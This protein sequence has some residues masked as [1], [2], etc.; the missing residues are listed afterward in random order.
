MMRMFRY[1]LPLLAVLAG[2][3]K[4][5]QEIPVIPE[6]ESEEATIVFVSERPQT[7]D[8]TRTHWDGTTILWDQAD[9]IRMGYTVDGKWQNATGNAS[10]T[11][12]KLYGSQ[13]TELT[14]DGAVASFT[15]NISFTGTTQGE[16]VFYAVFPGGTVESTMTAAPVTVVTLPATQTPLADSF[17]RLADLMLGHS[18]DEYT[19]RP[20][21]P[22][23][24]VWDRVVAHGQITLKALPGAVSGEKVTS[25][26]LTAQE[27]A[28][29]VGPQNMNIVTGEYSATSN[30]EEPNKIVIKGDNLI[31]D[32]N[33]NVTF[34]MS[35]LPV[36][37]TSLTIEVATNKA[38]YIRSIPS[39]ERTFIANRRNILPINMSK[40]S[41]TDI[42]GPSYRL[43]T[44]NDDLGEGNYLI[45]YTVNGT[46]AYVLSGKASGNFGAYASN[47]TVTDGAIEY[48]EGNPYNIV[49]KRT[50]DGYS[51]KQGDYYLGYTLTST[52]K[53]NY[54]YFNT[55]YSSP[56]YDWT[57]SVGS[58]GDATITNVY[59]TVR[60][61][62]WN[63]TSGQER[64]ACY[65]GTQK[66]VQLYKL[67]SEIPSLVTKPAT[68]KGV[69]SAKLN[70]TFANLGRNVTEPR[71]LWGTS[72]DN[73]SNTLYVQDFDVDSG[74]FHATLSGLQENTT[75]YYQAVV[76]YCVDGQNYLTL[77][78]DVLSFRTLPE[79]QTT[80]TKPGYL[81]CGEIPAVYLSGTKADGPEAFPAESDSDYELNW[82]SWYRYGVTGNSDQKVVSH[83]FKVDGQQYRNYSML[84]DRTKKAALWVAFAMNTGTYPWLVGR[85]DKWVS[86]PALDDSWQPNLSSGYQE[87]STYSRGHQVASNDRRTTT[88][89]TRQT[90]YFSNMTPQLSG[91]NGGQWASLEEDIQKIGNATSGNDT[92]YVVT[93]PVFGSNYGTTKDKSGTDCAVPT[94]YFKCIMKVTYSN[95]KPTAAM[96][97]AYLMNHVNSGS[98][99]QEVT[100]RSLEELTGFDFFANI[101]VELQ[102]TA[103]NETHPTSDFPQ[104][105]ISSVN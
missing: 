35:I 85:N 67:E 40:A 29:L 77:Y 7:E 96:G 45:A 41:R 14:E 30:N 36:T 99:R 59:N 86:D 80:E 93:G 32:A 44:S 49:V 52:S 105:S 8:P 95:G 48:S 78:G 104:K 62:Q 79:G 54:L 61:I 55:T 56:Q 10:A 51:L 66:L 1:V 23:R 58:N 21:T 15:T 19:S 22:V 82:S 6:P 91:F 25:I 53:D 69:T 73:L 11:D 33:G 94:Q 5:E 97:A 60:V 100:I 12:A 88:H 17:D 89:Q 63:S 92:L 50:E 39:C 4:V 42:Q 47:I 43:V 31:V 16:H 37:I 9:F 102:D 2:C 74:E 101:P 64:F 81:S 83:T 26:T 18:I 87:S 76:E 70:A 34:W 90:T 72:A 28:D 103:E 27:G 68:E 75:F 46:S 98:V 57:I 3:K 84:Y 13:K 38:T 71:F 65:P 20:E 24:L